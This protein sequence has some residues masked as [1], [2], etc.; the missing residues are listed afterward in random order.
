MEDPDIRSRQRYNTLNVP[1]AYIGVEDDMCTCGRKVSI[2][3]CPACGR[4]KIYPFARK[5]KALLAGREVDVNEYKCQRCGLRFNDIDRSNNCEAPKIVNM[6]LEART[7]IE[8]ILQ[9]EDEEKKAIVRAAI[10]RLKGEET[11]TT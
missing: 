1:S 6:L 5:I 2:T 9:S 4:F 11:K 3:H 7:R 10:A 8:Q